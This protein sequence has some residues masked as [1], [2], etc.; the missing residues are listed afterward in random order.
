MLAAAPCWSLVPPTPA[1][2]P[3]HCLA[4]TLLPPHFSPS[5]HQTAHDLL[6]DRETV[7]L[8]TSLCLME[9]LMFL[10]VHINDCD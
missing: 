10:F 2:A 7:S 3:R 5:A 9:D 4:I 8:E 6:L 1:P